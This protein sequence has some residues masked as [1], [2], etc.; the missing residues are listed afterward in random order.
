MPEHLRKLATQIKREAGFF[1]RP[2]TLCLLFLVFSGLY[3]ALPARHTMG[4]RVA[5]LLLLHIFLGL[6]CLF[7]LC[8]AV[9]RRIREQNTPSFL[10][11][12]LLMSGGICLFGGLVLFLRPL[13]GQSNTHAGLY[14]QLH[15]YGGLVF[16]LAYL[17]SI[18][19]RPTSHSPALSATGVALAL[20]LLPLGMWA[21]TDHLLYNAGDYLR[22]LS[23][24]NGVQA[25]NPLFPASFRLTEE[26]STTQQRWNAQD[27]AYCTREG[28][29][30]E[31]GGE[32]HRSAHRQGGSD[33][34]YRRVLQSYEARQ[35]KQA[36]KWCQSCH[37]PQQALPNGYK[38]VGAV[39]C[40]T[41][42][43]TTEAAPHTGNGRFTLSIPENYPYDSAKAGW[44][45]F[46]HDY[47]LRVR[48][49]A[50]QFS[51]SKPL[52]RQAALCGSCH[53]QSYGVTQNHYRFYR[54]SDSFGEWYNSPV[55]G[56]RPQAIDDKQTKTCI[57]C[58]WRNASGKVSHAS[59][60]GNTALATLQEE[61]THQTE[62]QRFLQRS[63]LEIDI[64]AMRSQAPGHES[65]W[66]APLNAP[67]L[68][69][70][71]HLG[72][73]VL[74][75]IVIENR[76]IG[77]DFPSGYT[78]L[79]SV[80]LEVTLKDS[81]GTILGWNGLTSKGGDTPPAQS[82]QWRHFGLD[83]SGAP[84]IHN[85]RSEEITTLY[86]HTIPAGGAEVARFALRIP[87]KGLDGKPLRL[88][89]HLHA[90]LLHQAVRPDFAKWVLGNSPLVR[91]LP[92]TILTESDV[93]LP[94]SSTTSRTDT[95]D[96]L[97]DR[98]LRYGRALLAPPENPEL[99]GAIRSF[100]MAKTLSR[101]KAT[102]PLA[103]GKAFLREM[104]LLEARNQFQEA[105][106]RD[107]NLVEA[108]LGLGSV[109]ARQG[110]FQEAL[111]QLLPLSRTYPNSK[112]LWNEI[113]RVYYQ[114]G[115]Y[116]NGVEAFQQALSIAPDDPKLHFQLKQCYQ[117]LQR[118]AEARR[119]ET[120]GKYHAERHWESAIAREYLRLNPT[121]QSQT[122]PIPVFP[123]F[124]TK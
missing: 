3:L 11:S 105:L 24:T 55:S 48:P 52:L 49:Q 51:L 91:S 44:Q 58:H 121:M 73:Q 40:I 19:P 90:R 12:I 66:V 59:L 109:L 64:F 65:E 56:N 82:H 23:A 25:Q 8:R 4:L 112:E 81:A 104:A 77:H 111:H 43:A 29:H 80:W 69:R 100:R 85:N 60:G 124:T 71:P 120:I 16:A 117:R 28:C 89:L 31:I 37:E 14:W 107:P 86:H 87:T 75:D 36:K 1:F 102:V 61:N 39:D 62:T 57:T 116:T 108:Q 118:V 99:Q 6:L 2:L 119:E 110:Q 122:R 46:V 92:T 123:L 41:C 42:H 47:L 74:L 88:P 115:D 93:A 15:L 63:G 114:L 35:G 68:G 38:E 84:I 103:L 7:P 106:R 26:V 17:H 53:Q 76:N 22:D 27:S 72:E 78:D 5:F 70:F 83:R 94:L 54:T 9:W 10:R 79:K 45:R 101:D 18:R 33:P 30:V 67:L 97:S 113:G 20:F 13:R 96:S 32:W 21:G 95:P 34:F 50:H 98:F